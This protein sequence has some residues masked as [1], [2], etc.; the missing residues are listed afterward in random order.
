MGLAAHQL[1]L[2]G[3]PPSFISAKC[4]GSQGERRGQQYTV[5][6]STIKRFF[7]AFDAARGKNDRRA[8]GPSELKERSLFLLRPRTLPLGLRT[9][10]QEQ[11]LDA[12]APWEPGSLLTIPGRYLQHY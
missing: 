5:L 9:Q 8:T 2:R 12:G 7:R 6:Y 11:N 3:L 4:Q 1:L 10:D